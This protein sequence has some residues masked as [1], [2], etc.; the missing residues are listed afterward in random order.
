MMVKKRQGKNLID[1]VIQNGEVIGEPKRVKQVVVGHFRKL[2]SEEWKSRPMLDGHFITIGD[3][4]AKRDLEAEFTLEEVWAAVKDCNGNKAPGLDGFN[5]FYIQKNWEVMRSEILQFMHEFHSNGKLAKG[6][7]SSFIT[8]IPKKDS[9][10]DLV[11]YR[12]ISLVGSIYKIL[13]KVLSRRIKKVLPRLV[14]EV[15]TSFIGE[16][17]ILDRV[18]IANEIIE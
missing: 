13:A 12:P 10:A 15:Q 6:L 5:L 7:N 17:C 2:Y 9:P 11:D 8:L 16:R 14:S 18:L 1:I 3:D 4:E